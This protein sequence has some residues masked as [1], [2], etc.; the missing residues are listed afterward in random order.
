MSHNGCAVYPYQL[1]VFRREHPVPITDT[2]PVS[3]G[4]PPLV[5]LWVPSFS[6]SPQQFVQ[7]IIQMRERIT[8][9]YGLVVISPTSNLFIQLHNQ[10]ILLPRF[11]SA[12]NRVRDI[13]N[14]SLDRL[15]GRLDN[16]LSLYFLKFQPR[17]S[18]PS[19]MLVTTVFSSESSNPRSARN[20]RISS[21]ASR[22][23]SGVAAV[24]TKSS[25]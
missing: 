11:S 19:S 16:Q 24:T 23:S 12:E 18:K 9:A 17:K 8:C 3:H 10:N 13:G 21:F 6:P 7:D 4:N 25:A 15:F 5:L 1:L 20:S 22:A 14:D 2:M